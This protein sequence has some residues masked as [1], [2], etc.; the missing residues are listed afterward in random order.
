M[1]IRRFFVV[2]RIRIVMKVRHKKADLFVEFWIVDSSII[3]KGGTFFKY[4]SEI[5]LILNKFC[6]KK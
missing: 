1:S 3:Y 2:V 4:M 5:S 6:L